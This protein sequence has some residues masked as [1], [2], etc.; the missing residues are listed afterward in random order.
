MAKTKRHVT[1]LSQDAEVAQAFAKNAPGADRR[2]LERVAEAAA[3][4]N[5]VSPEL[6]KI[7]NA[8]LAVALLNEKL[9]GRA[10]G[11]HKKESTALKGVEMAYC[12]FERLDR[13]VCARTE[14][15]RLVAKQFHVDE[16]HVERAA[17]DYQWLLGWSTEARCRFRAWRGCVS[18]EEYREAVLLDLRL[19][20][21]IPP[22][23]Q[24]LLK[25]RLAAAPAQ[26]MTMRNDLLYLV[27]RAAS[28]LAEPD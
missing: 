28:K 19:H 3:L 16:R 12:Y 23:G 24:P 11:R 2:V 13:A 21:G 18:N 26:V 9:P 8:I 22:A 27:D 15:L 20:E 25:E 17:R 6:Q 10:A 7:A 14:A 5:V 4:G 1:H